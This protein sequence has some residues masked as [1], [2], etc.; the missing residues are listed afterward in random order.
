MRLLLAILAVLGLLLAPAAA[1]AA[2]ARCLHEGHG[3]MAMG[4]PSGTAMVMAAEAAPDE[5]A[6][7]MPCCDDDAGTPQH[8]RQ[9]CAQDCALMCAPPVALPEAAS[10]DPPLSGHARLT[11]HP[12]K[13]CQGQAPPGLK[14]PP[15]A[16]I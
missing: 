6:G 8:D 11:A 15:R 5:A 12:C 4:M 9:A 1:A 3:D 2:T 16:F 10:P 13:P 14:R 7:P